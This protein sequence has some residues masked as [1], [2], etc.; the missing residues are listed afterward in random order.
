M[1]YVSNIT[2]AL[3]PFEPGITPLSSRVPPIASVA[4]TTRVT[5]TSL[6]QRPPSAT[7][8]SSAETPLESAS[9]SLQTQDAAVYDG[10]TFFSGRTP[11]GLS[12]AGNISRA[13][14]VAAYQ[15]LESVGATRV[16]TSKA[17]SHISEVN[18]AE[19]LEQRANQTAYIV[20]PI[21]SY[22]RNPTERKRVVVAADIMSSPVFTLKEN[23][24]LEEAQRIFQ[25]HKF[26]HI[27]IVSDKGSL[28]GIVSDRDFIGGTNQKSA[29]RIKEKMVT[30]ILTAHP[31]TEIRA[32]AQVMIDHH[33]GCL[34]ITDESGSLVG[35]LTRTD[36]LHAIVNQAP[37]ELWT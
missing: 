26:R 6:T 3:V 19:G 27:P 8:F 33:I 29:A 15:T 21:K 35:I 11:T 30:N 22:R 36:I 34:P 4:A 10:H 18:Q 23:T 25:D 13:G 24:S 20:D 7:E 28:V 5:E 32:I 2:G 12:D 31:Q 16:E 37:I 17:V 14:A 1:F 9:S